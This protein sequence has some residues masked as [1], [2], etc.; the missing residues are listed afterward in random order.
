[1]IDRY[2]ADEMRKR[3]STAKAYQA[4]LRTHIKPKWGDYELNQIR[5]FAV[6]QWLRGLNLAAK[7][8]GH[9]RNIMLNNF[10]CV[11]RWELIP[12]GKNPL[13]L[14]RVPDISKRQSKAQVLTA[15]QVT[16]L[17]GAIEPEPFPTGGLGR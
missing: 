16:E 12:M 9:I 6:E 4:Y 10:N 2:I 1:L 3:Y 13:S 14:V 17:I 15:R 5:P 7:S 11:M 8:K